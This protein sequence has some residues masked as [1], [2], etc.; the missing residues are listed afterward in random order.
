MVFGWLV[1]WVGVVM[2]C[3][4]KELIEGG[5]GENDVFSYSFFHQS[6]SFV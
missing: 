6:L 2:L 1:G 3:W 5:R 4:M